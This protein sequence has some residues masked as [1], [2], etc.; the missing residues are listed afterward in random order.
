MDLKR[1]AKNHEGSAQ[2]AP[3]SSQ[4]DDDAWRKCQLETKDSKRGCE[5]PGGAETSSDDAVKLARPE[6]VR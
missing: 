6:V 5:R 2:I 3:T 1:D 4:L